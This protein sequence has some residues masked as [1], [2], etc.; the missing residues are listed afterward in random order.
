MP[1]IFIPVDSVLLSPVFRGLNQPDTLNPLFKFIHS[2][3]STILSSYDSTR[4]IESYV[5]PE[6]LTVSIRKA[7]MKGYKD[8]TDSQVDI[9]S[10]DKFINSWLKSL[11]ARDLYGDLVY[12]QVRN[13]TDQGVLKSL[14]VLNSDTYRAELN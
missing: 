1:D 3:R 2:Q 12:Y 10:V 14:E 11:I 6:D 7:L 9:L 8:T 5:V 4:F 13:K